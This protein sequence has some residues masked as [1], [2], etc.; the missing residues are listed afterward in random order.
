MYRRFL[1]TF[2]R[3]AT[4]VL[5]VVCLGCSAQSA[6][7]EVARRIE[8]QVRSFY[9]IPAGVKVVLGDLKPSEFPNY[10]ALTITFDG[11]E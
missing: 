6:P 3:R 11:G 4:L 7:P 8:Q 1:V 2:L 10:D 9:N 5:L